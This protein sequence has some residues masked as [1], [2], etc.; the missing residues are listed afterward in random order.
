MK[1][2]VFRQMFPVAAAIARGE[3]GA[4][5]HAGQRTGSAGP[6]TVC[7]TGNGGAPLT[8]AKLADMVKQFESEEARIRELLARVDARLAEVSPVALGAVH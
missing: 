8:V 7:E 2:A 1:M 3:R 5:G 4:S 6:D